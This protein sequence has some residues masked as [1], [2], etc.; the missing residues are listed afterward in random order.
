M[1]KTTHIIIGLLVIFGVSGVGYSQ[2]S[3]R[4]AQQA[5]TQTQTQ[6]SGDTT[7][8]AGGSAGAGSGSYTLSDV[9]KHK[10]ESSCWS[11]INTTF[12]SCS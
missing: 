4:Q 9:V 11:A 6:D 12:R 10:G 7:S 3:A 1:S 5:G 8:D 2:F